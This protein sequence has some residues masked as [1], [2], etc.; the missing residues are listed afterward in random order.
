MPLYPENLKV[1]QIAMVFFKQ[2]TLLQG[3]S[4]KMSE[5]QTKAGNQITLSLTLS[6]YLTL[7]LIQSLLTC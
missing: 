5:R 1:Y 7:T 6:H 2:A 4:K 3:G